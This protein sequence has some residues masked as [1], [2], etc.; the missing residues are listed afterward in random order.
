MKIGIFVYSESGIT[1]RAAQELAEMLVAAGHEPVVEN[2][3]EAKTSGK[4]GARVE[5]SYADLRKPSVEGSDAYIFASA[6]HAFSLPPAMNAWLKALPQ[7]GGKKAACFVTK[8]LKPNW[9]GGN[10]AIARMRKAIEASG[11]KVV[12]TGIAH[13]RAASYDSELRTLASGIIAA[14]PLP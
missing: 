3:F 13:G 12:A 11:A 8:S 6:V 14:F 4:S 7:L 9:T 10:Q 2:L 1:L 5:P